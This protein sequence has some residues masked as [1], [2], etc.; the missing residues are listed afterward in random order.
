MTHKTVLFAALSLATATLISAPLPAPAGTPDPSWSP[1]ASERLVKLP[2]S[3][4]EK[5]IQQ[6]FRGSELGI[7]I[8]KVNED[9]ALKMQTL[10]DLHGAIETAGGDVRLELRHQLLAQKR[11]LVDLM[12]QKSTFQRKHL[13]TKVRLFSNILNDMREKASGNDPARQTLVERQEAAQTRFQSAIERV[14]MKIFESGVAPESHYSQKY[15]ENLQA[16]SKLVSRIEGHRLNADADQDAGGLSKKEY[17]Q[18]MLT[19]TEAEIA[20]IDQEEKIVG[21]M[22]K[23]V[24]LDALDLAEQAMDADQSDSSLPAQTGAAVVVDLFVQ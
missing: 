21:Y 10:K 8:D 16:I 2:A 17:I 12:S 23:L 3:Y 19:D 15:A 18:R 20:L 7:A 4:L 11:E 1:Q 5:S 6:D 13:K 14:D 24:S 22:A 9:I